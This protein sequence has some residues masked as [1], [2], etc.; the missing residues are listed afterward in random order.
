MERTE[1]LWMSE[2]IAISLGEL[3]ITQDFKRLGD[4]IQ[5]MI[6]FWKGWEIINGLEMVYALMQYLN[7][8]E[9]GQY[10][11]V[12]ERL[13][14]TWMS[15]RGWP[16]PEYPREAGQYL[17]VL[18]RLGSTWMPWRGWT[19]PECPGEAGQYLNVL[20]RLDSTWMSWRGWTVPE[21]PGERLGST[22]TP[23]RGW[24]VPECPSV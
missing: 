14:N 9:A 6:K 15:W 7:V 13:G 2:D 16:V 17:N 3:P 19:V 11:N 24:A 5:Y 4:K 21:C 10:M 22:W 20:E 12:P 1:G 23:W 18:E 8:L